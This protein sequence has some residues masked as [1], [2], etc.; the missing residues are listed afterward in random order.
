MGSRSVGGITCVMHS[1]A[2][3]TVVL[4]MYILELSRRDIPSHTLMLL[5]ELS[6]DLILAV[7]QAKSGIKLNLILYVW[8][9]YFLFWDMNVKWEIY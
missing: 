3:Q 6:G 8:E 4:L 2:M 7:F 9:Y 1:L 5:S